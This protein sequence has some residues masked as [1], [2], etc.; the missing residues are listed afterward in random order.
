MMPAYKES[1]YFDWLSAN[2]KEG[3]VIALMGLPFQQISSGS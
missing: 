1:S 2:V 3:N